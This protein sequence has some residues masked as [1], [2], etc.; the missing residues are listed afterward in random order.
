VVGVSDIFFVRHGAT[1]LAGTFCG[2]SDPSLDARGRRQVSALLNEL[3]EQAIEVVYASDLRR[4]QETGAMLA[5]ARGIPM[6]TL[7]GLREIHFGEWEGLTWQAIERRDPE[8]AERWLREYPACA[9]PGGEPLD[10]F[11]ARVLKT[12]EGLL[13]EETRAMVVVSHAGVIRVVLQQLLGYSADTCLSL[14]KEYC[15]VVR[16]TKPRTALTEMAR[17][18]ARR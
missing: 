9:A 13:R 17:E 1:A 11:E 7:E 4:A 10:R 3:A 18:Q 16:S 5:A 14:T 15:C 8:Y 12:M 6:H 2:Q